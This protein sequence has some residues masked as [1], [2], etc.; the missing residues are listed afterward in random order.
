MTDGEI[1]YRRP[2][3]LSG[4]YREHAKPGGRLR[5]WTR[6][7]DVDWIFYCPEC[8]EQIII[9]EEKLETAKQFSWTVTRRAATRH[10]DR[11]WAWQ[12]IIHAEGDYTVTRVRNN[13]T[14]HES[15]GPE[16]ISEDVFIGWIEEAFLEHYRAGE[17][18]HQS[19]IPPRFRA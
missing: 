3:R 7:L 8:G 5:D 10:Q 4:V 18:S 13:G 1:T 15:F 2:S 14:R 11:P 16:R 12:V 6:H 19:K 17:S 9:Q